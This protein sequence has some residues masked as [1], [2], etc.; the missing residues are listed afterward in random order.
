MSNRMGLYGRLALFLTTVVWGTSF[1]ILKTTLNSVGTL[2]VLAIRFT[3]SAIILGFV[4]GKKLKRLNSRLIKGGALMGLCLAAAYIVQTYGL[5]YTTPGK[6]SFL[7][8]TYC[9]LVPFMAWGVY[10]RR[11]DVANILAAFLC[12]TGIGY[13]SLGETIS[14]INIGDILTLLCSIFYALHIIVVEQYVGDGDALSLS[15][16]Q[17]AV[18]GIICL[19]GALILEAVPTQV[20]SSAWFSIAYL[21]VLCTAMCFFLQAWGIKYTPSSTAAV[22]L[23]LEAVFGTLISVLFYREQMTLKLVLGFFLIFVAVLISETKP[24]FLQRRHKV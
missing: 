23:S 4:A 16:V 20:P 17:F 15:T 6:N 19:T 22:I 5:L 2:W 21:S 3:S 14:N 13:V 18:A 24:K 9:V 12:I 10:K 1:V 11:P 7:T 8:A